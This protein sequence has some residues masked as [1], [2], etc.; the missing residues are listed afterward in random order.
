[1]KLIKTKPN[2]FV[3]DTPHQLLNAI[4]AVHSLQLRNNH[5]FAL[6]KPKDLSQ[7]RFMPLIRM[8]DWATVSFP[9]PF[10][11]SRRWV[12][13]LFGRVANRWYCRYLNF[14]RM[15]TVA[16]LTARFKNVDKLFVG[17]YWAEEKPYMRHIANAIRYDALYLL[18]DGTDTIDINERR[19]RSEC[20]K[21]GT[22]AEKS[23]TRASVY[24]RIERHLRAKYW[25]WNVAEASNVT[26]F[27]VYDIDV[28]K[29]DSLIRNNYSHLRSLAPTEKICMPDTVMFIGDCMAE[30]YFEVN[31]HF[32][33][34]SE[35]RKYFADKKLIYVAHPR[36]SAF[37]LTQIRDHMQCEIWPAF[38]VIEHDLF[39]R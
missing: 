10:I 22:Q 19:N 12:Q 7:G 6:L 33:F 38:S 21:Q 3:V 4:E 34:L 36:E 30:G 18:D 15:Y 13:E 37:C 29:G 24:K 32:E 8:S 1:M 26:F 28:R 25:N 27:T 17:H 16:K 39:T 31:V 5:L 2:V 14:Q 23:D 35:V 11:D 20:N 9:S